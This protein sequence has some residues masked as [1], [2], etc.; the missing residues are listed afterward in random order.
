MAFLKRTFIFIVINF[1]IVLTISTLLHF[2]HIQPY[3]T[4]Y[5]IDYNNL[6]LFC[7]IWGMGGA[8]IS[9]LLSRPIARLMMRVKI[10]DPHHSHEEEWLFQIVQKL[11]KDA[12]LSA[13]PLVGIY[14]S[15]DINAFATGPSSKRALIALSDSLLRSMRPQEIEAI[16]GHEISH[17]ANGD[18]VT[19]TLLQ[20]VAN[21]F[22]MFLARLLALMLSGFNQNKNRSSLAS[23]RMFTFLFEILF[24]AVGTLVLAAFSRRREFRA[25]HGGALLAGKENMIQALLSLQSRQTISPVKEPSSFNTLKIS[26]GKKGFYHLFATHP[27]M[28]ERIEKLKRL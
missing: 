18:M 19:M 23:F 14:P 20:G 8:I 11:S 2:F 6:L 26:S 12:G 9:L 16:I 24:M 15:S 25:D 27:P 22:V 7:L 1:F 10:I 17:I 3:L 5:G 28:E 21:A 13:T 4:S